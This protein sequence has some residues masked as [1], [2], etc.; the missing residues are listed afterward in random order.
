MFEDMWGHMS[1]LRP[2]AMLGIILD[3]SSTSFPEESSL[4]IKPRAHWSS[5]PYQLSCSGS[6]GSALKGENY[7]K[8][9]ISVGSGYVAQ[10]AFTKPSPRLGFLFFKLP[11]LPR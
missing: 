4:S 6:P 10:Q 11:Q 2:E 9:G 7:G 5:Q 1:T 8:V 3:Q